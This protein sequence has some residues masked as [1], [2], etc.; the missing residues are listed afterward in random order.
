MELALFAELLLPPHLDWTHPVLSTTLARSPT[1]CLYLPFD[2]TNKINPQM[3]GTLFMAAT[4]RRLRWL[5]PVGCEFLGR[6]KAST[7]E[8][9]HLNHPRPSAGAGISSKG[10]GEE[11]AP[12]G[13]VG[14][15][16]LQLDKGRSRRG[17]RRTRYQGS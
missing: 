4:K 13:Q 2:G 14:A 1:S 5:R 16:R 15:R 7:P 9:N 17:C 12:K 6:K 8:G 3:D 11:G 10:R